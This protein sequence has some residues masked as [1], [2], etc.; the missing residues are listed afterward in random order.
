MRKPQALFVT[1][2]YIFATTGWLFAGKC[3]YYLD[4]RL[5]RR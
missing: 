1:R 3:L 5:P 2:L 4:S